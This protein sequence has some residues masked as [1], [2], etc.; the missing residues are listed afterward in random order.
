MT[1]EVGQSPSPAEFSVEHYVEWWQQTHDTHEAAQTMWDSAGMPH[2]DHLVGAVG[3]LQ[4]VTSLYEVGCGSGPNLRRLRTAYPDLRL[5]G[6]EPCDGL[7][8]WVEEHLGIHPD[9]TVLPTSPGSGW[10]V[11][12]S[13]YVLAYLDEPTVAQALRALHQ[14]RPRALIVVEPDGGFGLGQWVNR[15]TGEMFQP[16]W[17]H[18]YLKLLSVTGWA[19]EWRWPF[20]RVESIRSL[21]VA[22]PR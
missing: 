5:G 16:V 13:C 18:D 14:T 22:V 9:R 20:P 8:T 2:R 15:E 12:V 7:A 10:D 21:I 4:P 1:V 17:V 11:I 3:L 19:V 6:S